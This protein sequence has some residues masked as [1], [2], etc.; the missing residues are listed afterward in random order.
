MLPPAKDSAS[1]WFASLVGDAAPC[2]AVKLEDG[3]GV[4]I[5]KLKPV[6]ESVNEKG[7]L[8]CPGAAGVEVT[9]GSTLAGPGP[10][11]LSA[12]DN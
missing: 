9:A 12:G 6:P 2:A 8:P 1:S 11:P 5:P 7:L 10:E 3:V 4:I